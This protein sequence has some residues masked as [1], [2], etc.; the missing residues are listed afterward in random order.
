MNLLNCICG[1]KDCLQ[2]LNVTVELDT[3]FD[4]LCK[5]VSSDDRG[6]SVDAGN[7]KLCYN[8]FMEKAEAKEK[9]Q[10][11]EQARKVILLQGGERE[12]EQSRKV[13][14]QERD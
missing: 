6:K 13:I 9:E 12:G 8:S 11:R 3:T 10:E 5:W 4:Q 2:D 14:R 1:E 7:M